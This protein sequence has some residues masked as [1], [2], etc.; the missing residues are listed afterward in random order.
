MSLSKPYTNRESHTVV[1]AWKMA[2]KSSLPHTSYCLFCGVVA[3]VGDHRHGF[4][5]VIH[6]FVIV[7]ANLEEN[8]Y[9]HSCLWEYCMSHIISL[10]EITPRLMDNRSYWMRAT[11]YTVLYNITGCCWSGGVK[12]CKLQKHFC[13]LQ[14]LSNI[15]LANQYT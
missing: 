10:Q 4:E 12:L 9:K 13:N 14:S 1:H 11:K 7:T 8:P 6:L 3:Q 5:I 15:K 2:M